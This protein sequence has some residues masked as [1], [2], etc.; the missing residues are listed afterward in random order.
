MRMAPSTRALKV[1]VYAGT[2]SMTI[3]CLVQYALK[4]ELR[5]NLPA[6]SSGDKNP[7]ERSE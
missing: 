5:A 7:V 6:P 1:C 2:S 4:V 3:L